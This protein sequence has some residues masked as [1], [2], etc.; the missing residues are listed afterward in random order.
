MFSRALVICAENSFEA[1]KPSIEHKKVKHKQF[2]F[3]SKDYKD[4]HSVLKTVCGHWRK[5]GRPSDNSHPAKALVL[6]SRRNLQ[7]IARNEESSKSIKLADDL[8]ETFKN[9]INK[10]CS[11][12]KKYRG[13]EVKRSDISVIETLA[14]KFSGQNVLEGFAKNT[15]ILCSN[16][17]S[18]NEKYDNGIYDMFV[19]D[20][21]IIFDITTDEEVKIPHINLTQLKKIIF[22][23]LKPNKACDVFMLTVEH[24]RSAGDE[25]LII[26]L[27]LL[28]CIID[29]INVVSSPQLNTSVA[30]VVYKG[31]DKPVSHHKSYRLVRVTP[32]FGRLIDEYMRPDLIEIVRPVQNCNQ[33][34][35]TEKVSYL[36]GA[37]QRHEVEKYCMDMKRT[38]LGCSLDGDSAFEVVNRIIQTRELYCA[39]ERGDFWQASHCSYQNSLTKIKM[40]GHLSRDITEDLGVKQG[41][42]KS[43]DHY[44]IYIAPLLDTLDSSD[45]GVWVG[46][47]NISVSGVADDVY[48]MSDKQTELQS[49]LDIAAHYGRMYRIEYGASKTKITVVGSEVDS[50]YYKDISPWK[51]NDDV[52][53]VVEDNEHLGQVVSGKNQEEKNVD[54]R[55]T[56]GRK[57]LFGLFGV[58]FAFKCFLSPVVKLHIYRTYVCPVLRSGLSS[59]SLQSSHLEPLALFQRKILKS[60]L[61]L[62]SSAPTPAIHFLTG[63]LPM[64]GKLHR[65]LFSLFF[66]VWNNPDTKI[67][68]ILKYLLKSSP[69]NSRTWA[70]HLRHLC[71]RYGL[72]DPLVYLSRDPPT[73]SFWKELIAT[74]ITSYFENK[75]RNTASTNSLMGYLNT[76]ECGLRGRHHPALANMFTTW[77]VK[78]SRSHLKFLSGNYLTYKIKSDQSGGS[79]RCRICETGSDE[80]VSHVI[81]TCQGLT[82]EREKILTDI[83]KLCSLTKNKI[84]FE[85]FKE[86]EDKL[87]QFILDPTSLNLPTR[88]SLQ[89]PLVP[90]FYKLSRDLCHVLDNTRIRLLRELEEK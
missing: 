14:G 66:G 36:M 57:C 16:D 80:T 6:Q 74:K 21:M 56:K 42:N 22:Q 47:I 63:E 62:S 4:A 46:P 78:K 7:S 38:F 79:P 34:G 44:K 41:R 18:K 35:F 10:V 24:L 84:N 81:S 23:K 26:I 60:T 70:V 58:G 61:K 37:L 73:R 77:E 65:D 89:D 55:I 52:V 9:D 43:S 3:F 76:Y 17:E 31:K 12:L 11:K 1:K 59:F 69:D 32:L 82:V 48:L 33:Y 30:S 83:S 15:E 49:L 86:S 20:N 28:N 85:E 39:G 51:M 64:E 25:T 67:Y 68:E 13:E 5:A 53:K 88:V 2:P 75:L 19:K 54:L 72:E 8:M 29:N 40:N 45:L 90:E 27:E 87:C 50:N 71:T